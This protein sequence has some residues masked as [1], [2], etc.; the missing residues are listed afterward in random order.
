L[1][2]G[3]SAQA[4]APAGPQPAAGE[5]VEVH[6]V[7][8]LLAQFARIQGLRTRYREEKRIALLK[9]PLVSEGTIQFARPGLLL[10]TAE[11]PERVTLLLDRDT[12]RMADASGTHT[13]ALSESPLV[14]NFVLTFVNVL[15]GDRAALER[16]YTLQFA[17]LEGGAWRLT[18]VPKAQDLARIVKRATLEGKGVQVARMTLEE[19]NG[20]STAL[21]FSETDLNVNFDAAAR[22]RIFRL[23]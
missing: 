15:S 3:G 13:I 11:K 14:R 18:L 9:R 8:D 17:Q 23:P 19:D 2:L 7:E 1:L 12:L 6:S 21:S 4:D 10:R 16:Q 22:A 5:P 20:D